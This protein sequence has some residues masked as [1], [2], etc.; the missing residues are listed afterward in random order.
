VFEGLASVFEET[1]GGQ[2]LPYQEYDKHVIADWAAELFAQPVDET[3][4]QWKFEHP[5]GRRN[6][7]YRVGTWIADRAVHASGRSVAELVWEA[8][9]DVVAMADI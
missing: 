3:W 7:A 9:D 2:R 5:D 4:P 8:P 1:A 6:I